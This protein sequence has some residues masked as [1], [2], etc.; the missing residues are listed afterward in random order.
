MMEST[1]VERRSRGTVGDLS[2]RK[3]EFT[4][5]LAR[6]LLFINAHRAVPA[7]QIGGGQRR[8]RRAGARYCYDLRNVLSGWTSYA[9]S[10]GS[11]YQCEIS[12]LS[13]HW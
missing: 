6:R 12:V 9:E 1:K 3:D 10:L 5:G 11:S 2:L 13:G 4:P 8:P 7:I